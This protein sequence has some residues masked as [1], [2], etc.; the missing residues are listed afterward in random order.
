MDPDE[1]QAL[2]AEND[3]GVD[4]KVGVGVKNAREDERDGAEKFEDAEGGPDG[5]RE[6]SEGRDVFADFVEEK[7]F[8]DPGG[9]V[10]KRGDDLQNP[11]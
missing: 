7:N 9:S 11:Q 6:C 4:G 10:E 3:R 2:D 5:A 1:E 8:H